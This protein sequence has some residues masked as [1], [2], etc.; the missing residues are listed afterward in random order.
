MAVFYHNL[1]NL[2]TI[3]YFILDQTNFFNYC[4]QGYDEDVCN[5]CVYVILQDRVIKVELLGH[6]QYMFMIM[7]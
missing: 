2:F 3:N 7:L 4:K 5:P 6:S 1:L